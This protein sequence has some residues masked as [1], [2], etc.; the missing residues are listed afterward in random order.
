[1]TGLCYLKYGNYSQLGCK[2][3][4]MW[5]NKIL[6]SDQTITT[7]FCRSVLIFKF[8]LSL[9]W[10]QWPASTQWVKMCKKNIFQHQSIYV[11]GHT[12]CCSKFCFHNFAL[13]FLTSIFD[14]SIPKTKSSKIGSSLRDL[15]IYLYHIKTTHWLSRV[16]VSQAT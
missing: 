16:A 15:N 13:S 4:S 9:F 12:T 14:L 1:M 2:S 3:C 6:I 10:C 5:S 8:Q 7:G 11:W